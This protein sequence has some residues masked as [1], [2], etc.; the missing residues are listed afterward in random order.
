M[1]RPEVRPAGGRLRV[2]GWEMPLLAMLCAL[3]FWAGPMPGGP[4][5]GDVLGRVADAM[6]AF[7]D[8]LD[9]I[10]KGRGYRVLGENR[11]ID[12][13]VK[14][15]EIVGIAAAIEGWRDDMRRRGKR[16]LSIRRFTTYA[17]RCAAWCSQADFAGASRFLAEKRARRAGAARPM[18]NARPPSGAGASTCTV[19]TCATRT[20]SFTW[21]RRGS[22]ASPAPARPRP[23][24]S[25]P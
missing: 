24:N 2:E 11:A 16:D 3:G 6:R 18:T 8:A 21:R 5:E 15:A 13:P 25:A 22:P 10:G 17:E 14:P 23:R 9:F 1:V 7:A 4:G 12:A 20:R 19:P